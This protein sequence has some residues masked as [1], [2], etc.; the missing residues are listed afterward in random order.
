MARV[1]LVVTDLIFESRLTA[2]LAALG[3][4]VSV[5]GD[6]EEALGALTAGVDLMVL[7]LHTQGLLPDQ[8]IAAAREHSVPVLAFG[9]HT[10]AGLLR[11]ARQAGA[12]AVVP[13]SALFE[14]LPSL[15]AGLLPGGAGT[16]GQRKAAGA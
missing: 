1:L 10:A 2:A 6:G 11:A 14:E 3:H 7:D 8:A 15:V 9:R 4:Q 5:V 12:Q 16:E 13:R